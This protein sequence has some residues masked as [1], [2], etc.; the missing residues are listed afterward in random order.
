MNRYEGLI[1][2]SA[3]RVYD[4][5]ISGPEPAKKLLNLLSDVD[6]AVVVY[7]GLSIREIPIILNLSEKSGFSSFQDRFVLGG[8]S[9]SVRATY[10]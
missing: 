2:S 4:E 10:L 1:S 3:P 9:I 8:D 6:T 5:L 7:D